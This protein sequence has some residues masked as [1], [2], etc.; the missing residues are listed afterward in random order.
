VPV[1][2]P[3]PL[4]T[5][6]RGTT[7]PNRLR[8]L[9]R[10]IAHRAA[11]PLRRVPSALVVDLGFGTS[12]V[13]TLELAER[14]AGRSEQPVAVLGL[15]IDPDRVAAAR[16]FARPGVAFA[17]GGFEV[18]TPGGQQPIVIRVANV[19]RQYGEPEVAPAWG[20]MVARLAPD[21]VLVEGT[22]DELGRLGAWVTLPAGGDA[23][24]ESLTLSVDLRH[25]DRPSQ[26]ATRLPKALIHRNVEGEPVHRLLAALDGAW[27]RAAPHAAFGP[28]Q[29]WIAAIAALR[30]A[31]WPVADGAAR[32]RL[33]ECTV[34]WSAVAPTGASD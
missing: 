29:R 18:P 16:Q 24:P 5:V 7:S 14:L 3:A 17:L 34:A 10:W 15:E 32:W 26:V 33:G 4:G 21:G 23:V 6:T 22:C 30:V 1:R 11:G 25:L 13:T 31:G 9:D 2:A 28:R 12:P 19:L 27:D 8:R 20:A